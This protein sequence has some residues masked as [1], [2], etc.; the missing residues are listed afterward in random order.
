MFTFLTISY[1]QEKYIIEHLE[2][3]KY[4]IKKYANGRNMYYILADDGSSDNTVELAEQWLKLNSSLF[5]DVRILDCSKNNGTVFNYIRAINSVTT[6]RYKCLAADDLYYVNNVIDLEDKADIVLS[7]SLFF[8]DDGETLIGKNLFYYVCAGKKDEALKKEIKKEL[9]YYCGIHAPGSFVNL[10][11]TQDK[12]F[13]KYLSQFK[14]IEDYPQWYYIF[15]KYDKDFSVSIENQIYTLYRSDVGISSKK[16]K[17]NPLFVEEDNRIKQM[18]GNKRIRYKK[19]LNVY[20]YWY[21]LKRKYVECIK[22]NVNQKAKD[23]K[24]NYGQVQSEAGEYIQ[25]IKNN[26]EA[27]YR[28]N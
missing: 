17:R 21:T 1:N 8:S 12:Q 13:Q 23:I 16:G 26:V 2:S 5:K 3:I 20:R 10:N 11:I 19:Y 4:Q 24:N 6:L 9:A 22:V 14:W 28:T 7:P 25:F 18:I 27:F 15:N